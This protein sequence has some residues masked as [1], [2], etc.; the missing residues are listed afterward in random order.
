MKLKIQY[1][2]EILSLP[3]QLWSTEIIHVKESPKM[4]DLRVILEY[5]G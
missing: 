2:K 5:N 3:F 1:R 4:W